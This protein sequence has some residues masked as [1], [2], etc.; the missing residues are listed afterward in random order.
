MKEQEMERDVML[1][2]ECVLMNWNDRQTANGR[3]QKR[4]LQRYER[5]VLSYDW[6]MRSIDKRIIS[7]PKREPQNSYDR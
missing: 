6:S 4:L 3:E 2:C 7:F 5:Y 1:R